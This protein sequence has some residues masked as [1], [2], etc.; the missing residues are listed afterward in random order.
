MAARAPPHQH[1]GRLAVRGLRAR[2]QSD[3]R[4]GAADPRYCDQPGGGLRVGAGDERRR[5]A[6]R[7]GAAARLTAAIS[8]RRHGRVRE[9]AA[10]SRRGYDTLLAVG[11]KARAAHA[12]LRRLPGDSLSTAAD[13]PGVQLATRRV[14]AHVG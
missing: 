11:E 9:T 7:S 2:L 10:V 4:S 3:L 8:W 1:L 12:A 5:R 6:E 13:V 14:G